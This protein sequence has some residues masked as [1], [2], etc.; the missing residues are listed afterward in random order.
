MTPAPLVSLGVALLL[1]TLAVLALWYPDR[2]L[3]PPLRGLAVVAAWAALAGATSGWLT[4]GLPAAGAGGPASLVLLVAVAAVAAEAAALV[5]A[6]LRGGIE[7]LVDGLVCGLTAGAVFAPLA[8]VG[9]LAAHG[10]VPSPAAAAAQTLLA[11]AGGALVGAGAAGARLLAR[12]PV[13]AVWWVVAA[14]AAFLVQDA[15]AV[16]L[17]PG[18]AVWPVR[19][20]AA[21]LL[22]AGVAAAVL[23]AAAWGVL[24]GERRVLE[25]QLEEERVFGVLPQW[26]VETIPRLRRRSRRDWWPDGDERRVVAQALMRLAFRKQRVRCLSP[27]RARL[28]GLAVGPLRDRVRRLL[29]PHWRAAEREDG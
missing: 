25:A 1:L 17:S 26:V 21:E 3:A 8:Q 27:G 11:A 20:W 18:R 4:A 15:G 5:L 19:P 14:A 24:A 28:A 12:G 9:A 16:V 2:E 10:A 22:V 6:L 23:A 7:G 13:A 29:D